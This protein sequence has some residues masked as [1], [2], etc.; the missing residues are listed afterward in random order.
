M[1]EPEGR[2]GAIVGAIVLTLLS[3]A[4]WANY[5]Y[6]YMIILG[7]IMILL[8]KFLPMGIVHPIKVMLFSKIYKEK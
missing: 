2:E 3:E 1:L 7:I 8:V 5:P 4:L 6:Y